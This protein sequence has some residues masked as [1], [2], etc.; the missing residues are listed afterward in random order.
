[1]RYNGLVIDQFTNSVMPAQHNT[2]YTVV[3]G[4]RGSSP[5]KFHL[6]RLVELLLQVQP[7]S[8]KVRGPIARDALGCKRRVDQC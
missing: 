1:M 3:V 5:N 2:L 4:S 6:I 7:K 8:M